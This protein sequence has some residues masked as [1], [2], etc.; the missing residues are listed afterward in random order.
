M[1]YIFL[2]FIL[3][4][5]S[6]RSSVASPLF[7]SLPVPPSQS[8]KDFLSSSLSL[9]FNNFVLYFYL[10]CC[11]IVYV[12]VVR[13]KI[14]SCVDKVCSFWKWRTCFCYCFLCFSV[15]VVLGHF[16]FF[17]LL[18]LF[19]CVFE[20]IEWKTRAILGSGDPDHGFS[21]RQ[22]A[23]SMGCRR[24]RLQLLLLAEVQTLRDPLGIY[25]TYMFDL[26]STA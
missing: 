17:F 8:R 26:F 4:G 15:F 5:C 21:E 22:R 13:T 20:I 9:D 24:T 3:C 6:H 12:Y 2:F 25:N 11:L 19:V 16:L 18:L 23:P 14:E 1:R 10:V 7:L